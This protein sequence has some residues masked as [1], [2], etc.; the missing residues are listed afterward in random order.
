MTGYKFRIGLG[1]A[2]YSDHTGEMFER[3]LTAHEQEILQGMIAG[4]GTP[5]YYHARQRREEYEAQN[6][7]RM[8]TFGV[9]GQ[10]KLKEDLS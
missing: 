6:L 5:H 3:S 10:H 9:G 8:Q 1:G 7:R 2:H 4:L